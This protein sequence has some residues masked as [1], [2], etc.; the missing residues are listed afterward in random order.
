MQREEQEQ[1]ISRPV[2]V[3]AVMGSSPLLRS[4]DPAVPLVTMVP[5]IVARFEVFED[6]FHWFVFAVK[7]LHSGT[8]GYYYI[9]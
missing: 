6:S 1:S 2:A 7:L 5:R 3:E 9:Q 4:Q 8:A